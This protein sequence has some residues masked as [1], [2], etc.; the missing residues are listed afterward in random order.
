MGRIE[1]PV[2]DGEDQRRAGL[3]LVLIG[4]VRDVRGVRICTV[5]EEKPDDL[6][7]TPERRDVDGLR[8]PVPLRVLRAANVRQVGFGFE[9]LFD[10][11]QVTRFGRAEEAGRIDEPVVAQGSLSMVM[12]PHHWAHLFIQAMQVLGATL[13]TSEPGHR[14]VALRSRTSV[15]RSRGGASR[16]HELKGARQPSV[17]GP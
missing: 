2:R 12:V 4:I 3:L 14:A 10:L 15:K 5:V 8:L 17:D 13:R 9:Y 7:M 11:P 16:E 6:K 1:M